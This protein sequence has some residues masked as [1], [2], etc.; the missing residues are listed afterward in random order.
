MAGPHPPADALP[1]P[2]WAVAAQADAAG[3]RPVGGTL[4]RS[5]G[6]IRSNA[7][8][9][10]LGLALALYL[11]VRLIGLA[12]FPIYFFTDEA[13]QSVLAGDLVQDGFHGYSGE[14]LPTYF[15]N[16]SQYNLSFSVYLQVIPFLLFGHSVYA[17]RAASVL[18]TLLAAL[19][20]SLALRD[21][22]KSRYAWLG[23]LLLS[24]TPVWFLHSRTAFETALGSTFFIVF[25]YCYGRYR[26]GTLN[27]LYGAAVFGALT[28]YTYS[29][30][31]MVIAVA[32][33]LLFFSDL[34][35]HW[36]HRKVV[37]QTIALLALF[38]IP[39]LRFQIQHPGETLHHLVQLDSY[40]IQ[41]LS[42]PQ[43]LGRYLSEYLKGLNPIYWYQRDSQGLVRH[44]MRNYG[45]LW[46][47]ALPFTVAGLLICLTRI[48]RP[49]YRLVLAALL[50][51][52]SG[53]A[54]VEIGPPRLL[55]MVAPAVLLAG[56][57]LSWALDGLER[58]IR[59]WRRWRMPVHGLV[60]LA[61]FGLLAWANGAM[62]VDALANGP[63][64]FDDYSLGGM[65]WGARQLFS[66]VGDYAHLHPDEDLLV[67]PTWTNGADVVTRFF[68]PD[69]QPFALGSIEGYISQYQPI[70]AND[71]FVMTPQE[72]K[73]VQDSGKFTGIDVDIT[74]DYPNGQPGFYFVHLR[75]VAN[76]QQIFAGEEQARKAL[77]SN[78]ITLP[79][80]SQAQAQYSTLDLGKIQD[81]F[82]GSPATL[83][84]TWESNPMR[85]L[86]TFPQ[87]RTISEVN[88]VVG[89]VP[90]KVTVLL[91]PPG[92]SGPLEFSRSVGEQPNPQ[93]VEVDF[94]RA[95]N[96]DHIEIQVLSVA[97]SEPAHVHAWE[98]TLK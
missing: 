9:W 16:A 81:L 83:A 84:R 11:A 49:E 12:D 79:D 80:G 72:M 27:Y 56:I 6:R 37:L 3:R 36:R 52:P 86:L 74:L 18:V 97:E 77:K 34:R 89:G 82:D 73:D 13:V 68:F 33:G 95:Y 15:P 60:S 98:I 42:L 39:Y 31:E 21:I 26:L 23:A 91:T 5:L 75:Y 64:W 54:L 92:A 87:P 96:V 28:F 2:D 65:Q 10:L 14:L 53:A 17:T 1:L 20:A 90:S 88:V 67:S 57:G 25:L 58:L 44:I 66:L 85:V 22:F 41:D 43:K 63:T 47:P 93:D 50:A 55:F 94:D 78:S 38:L 71:V 45:Y 19:A 30:G 8:A 69:F 4:R 40:W 61:V 29:P 51:A 48:R 70:D 76:I 7:A 46:R 59:R 62:L 24:V 35:Y 32:A